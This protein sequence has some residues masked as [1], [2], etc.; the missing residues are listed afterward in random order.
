MNNR[1]AW[2]EQLK[3]ERERRGLSLQ[4]ISDRTRIRMVYIEIIESG[5]IHKLPGEVF[6]RGFARA[7]ASALGVDF[8]SIQGDLNGDLA[9]VFRGG[10]G[11]RNSEEGWEYRDPWWKVLM[12]MPRWLGGL[13]LSGVGFIVFLYTVGLTVGPDVPRQVSRE[14]I[15]VPA[16]PA[17]APV[18]GPGT[19]ELKAY[20]VGSA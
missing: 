17:G 6:A 13:L 20:P 1:S 12:R 15:S 9:A 4:E 18:I 14:P 2:H 5:E 7:Y 10:R 3:T 16:V 8:R 11:E 19:V